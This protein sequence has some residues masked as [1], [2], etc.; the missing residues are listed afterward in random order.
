MFTIKIASVSNARSQ[1][2]CTAKH[3]KDSPSGS[4]QLIK[5]FTNQVILHFETTA[6]FN[7]FLKDGNDLYIP[8]KVERAKVYF[9]EKVLTVYDT[10]SFYCSAEV[11]PEG[12]PTKK[13]VF[14]GPRK[15]SAEEAQR[16]FWHMWN[17]GTHNF[18][19]DEGNSAR[20]VR[21]KAGYELTI[22]A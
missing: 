21:K 10:V 20:L 13:T 12:D 8:L 11:Y 19:T 18:K 1:T 7:A 17:H 4:V 3:I 15:D 22:V 14:E 16:M 2:V 5:Q 6:Q 9:C